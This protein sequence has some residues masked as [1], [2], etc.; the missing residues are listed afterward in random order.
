MGEQYQKEIDDNIYIYCPESADHGLGCLCI[1][2]VYFIQVHPW[3]ELP[4]DWV[5]SGLGGEWMTWVEKGHI[6]CQIKFIHM[7]KKNL[8]V[9]Y[10]K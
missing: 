1:F 9:T 6:F 3:A 10:E 2:L 5:C 8:S 4:A 7:V